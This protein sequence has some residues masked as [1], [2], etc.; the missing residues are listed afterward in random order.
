MSHAAA[1]IFARAEAAPCTPDPRAAAAR[2]VRDGQRWWA[3]VRDLEPTEAGTVATIEANLY[4]PLSSA[5]HDELARRASRPLGDDSDPLAKP[6]AIQHLDARCALDCNVFDYWRERP[7]APL[8]EALGV[9]D[10]D[11]LSFG[12]P[13]ASED[14]EDCDLWIGSES[15]RPTAVATRF[16]EPLGGEATWRGRAL[17]ATDAAMLPGCRGLALD[18]D[19]HP[20]RFTLLPID[21]LLCLASELTRRHGHR[22]FRM[23]FVW[24]DP[25]GCDPGGRVASRMRDEIDRFRMRAGGEIDFDACSYQEVFRRLH[26][27]DAEHGG[28]LRYLASRYFASDVAATH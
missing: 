13:D 4:R 8:C 14:A 20:D 17:A 24:Y 22:G 25:A 19:A 23:R 1:P 16:L 6:A 12:R 7:L 28:Y 3:A 15:E 27:A 18:L 9:P 21:A 26:G 5:T 10:A 11:T 2:A